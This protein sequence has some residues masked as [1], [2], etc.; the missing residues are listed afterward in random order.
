MKS[1]EDLDAWK[2]GMDLVEEV[3]ALVKQLPK[4]EQFGLSQQLRRAVTSVVANLA[5]GFSRY[6]C[7]DKANKFIIARGECSE[8]KAL[9]LITIRLRLLCRSEAEKGLQ[10]CDQTGKLL[11]GLT[12]YFQQQ[13][14]ISVSS[15]IPITNN[16]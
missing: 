9:L 16:Q 2:F 8:V 11:S 12:H 1:F 4:N 14:K 13:S 6:T 3:Y 5:E 15:T 7:L 10:L